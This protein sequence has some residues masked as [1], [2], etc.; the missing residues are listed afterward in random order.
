[1]Y[2]KSFKISGKKQMLIRLLINYYLNYEHKALE[3][4]IEYTCISYT[5]EKVFLRNTQNSKA[6][7]T[8]IDRF[9]YLYC[10][11]WIL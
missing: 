5:K 7:N 9:Y 8:N 11:V 1:M 10:S 4:T 6:I 3:K 2:K